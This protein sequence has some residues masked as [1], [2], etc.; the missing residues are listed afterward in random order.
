[1]RRGLTTSREQARDAVLAGRVLVGGALA[2]KPARLV[3]PD[4]P[5]ELVGVPPRFV[6]RGGEKLDA[7][8]ERFDVAVE[9]KRALD[10]GASTGGFTDCL[11]QWGA[12]SVVAVDVGYGQLHER[13]RA[14]PRVESHERSD[15]R[16]FRADERFELVVADLSF[17]S[18]R[19]VASALV[20]LAAPG[21]D[22]VVLVKPQFEA[23]RAEA[24]KGRGVI[25]DPEVRERAV[26]GVRSAMEE[27]GAA[28][29]EVMESPLTG[30]DGNVEFLVH[31][32]ASS[33]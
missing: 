26:A 6:G 25:R 10:A 11:L 23:G 19:T 14:D 5:V 1:V 2:D 20:E 13:L 12:S 24:S 32:R 31:F 8:L 4:E 33:R 22:L 3:A 30:A 16:A 9:G 27:A 17:I 15:I 28:M 7:A 18:L 21:A 29:M